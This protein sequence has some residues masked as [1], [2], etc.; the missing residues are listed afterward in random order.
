MMS[1][2]GP[3]SRYRT[4]LTLWVLTDMLMVVGSYLDAYLLHVGWILSSDYPLQRHLLVAAV[5]AP[6]VIILL[7]VTR[8]YALTRKQT[9]VRNAL[10]IL[11]CALVGTALFTLL[12]YFGFQDLFSRRLLAYAFA[13][14]FVGLWLWHIAFSAW[15][16]RMLRRNPPAFPTL[17]VGLTREA[18]EVITS[19]NTHKSPFTPVAILD[20]RGAK[21]KEVNGV[22][23]LGKLNVL[24]ETLLSKKITHLL[25][26]SDLEQTINL[27]SA[28]RS[29]GITYMVLPS[30][31]GIVERD[32]A[33]ETLEGHPV[34]VVRPQRGS[35]NWF[36]R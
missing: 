18:S 24:E 32:E 33:V 1:Y 34:T 36:F 10:Y 28:C 6:I 12:Y 3:V 7:T 8:T 9:T 31:F 19:M 30:V 4:L 26:C 15:M 23:V 25:Q 35:W 14:S 20:A 2:S 21:E 11:F 27:M 13:F 29:H 22:P 5:V 16:R 17:I